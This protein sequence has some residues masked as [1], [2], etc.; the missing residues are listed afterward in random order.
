MPSARCTMRWPR[1]AS[2]A[3]VSLPRID[4]SATVKPMRS[5]VRITGN[6]AGSSTWRN[7][8]TVGGAHRARRGDEDLVDIAEARDGVEH[9]R[10]E[11]DGGAERDLR[12][13]AE[14]EEQHIERQEQDD[15]H[16]IDAGQQRLEHLDRD[17]ASG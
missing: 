12:A 17:R 7:I 11:A 15:R 3:M 16:R 14:P 10:E 13:R 6:A 5:P 8:W 2:E 9:D 1:P 4:S